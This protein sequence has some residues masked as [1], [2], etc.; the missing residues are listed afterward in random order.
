MYILNSICLIVKELEFIAKPDNLWVHV[1]GTFHSFSS[2]SYFPHF[3][4]QTPYKDF[5]CQ[6]LFPV[7]YKS[8]NENV[9]P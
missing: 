3:G 8:R 1:M 7:A 4:K 6:S 9:A 5:Y 2:H